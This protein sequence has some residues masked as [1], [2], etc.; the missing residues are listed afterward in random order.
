[1]SHTPGPW[2]AKYAADGRGDIGIVA[3][4]GC[5]AE[6]FH[7]IRKKGERAHEECLANSRLIKTAPKLLEALQEL[8][9]EFKKLQGAWPFPNKALDK[10][11]SAIKEATGEE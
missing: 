10:A 9:V 11:D 6:C 1:M 2:V 8:V 7:E 3:D 4:S 5:I